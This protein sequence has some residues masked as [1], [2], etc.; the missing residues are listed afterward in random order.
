MP[1]ERRD[2]DAL[3]R[4]IQ[5]ARQTKLDTGP[6][7]HWADL[8]DS[9]SDHPGQLRVRLRTGDPKESAV[10]RGATVRHQ[11][12]GESD[13]HAESVITNSVSEKDIGEHEAI[14]FLSIVGVVVSLAG[15]DAGWA[16]PR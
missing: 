12:R 1:A 8:A 11:P 7:D 10:D 4:M 16:D 15:F 3:D 14:W 2:A 6:G 5:L 9:L 13:I